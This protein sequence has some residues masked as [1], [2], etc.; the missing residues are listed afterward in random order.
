MDEEIQKEIK[1]IGSGLRTHIHNG[2]ES[3]S[4]DFNEVYNYSTGANVISQTIGTAAANYDAYYIAEK[5]LSIL[6]IDFSAVDALAAHDTNFITWTIT[7]LGQDGTGS[8]VILGTETT[9]VTGG[10]AIAAN[11]KRT[12][13]LSSTIP[14]IQVIQGDRIRIRAAVSGTLANTVT[15]PVYFIQLTQ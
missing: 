15:F 13:T 7:N 3:T 5:T 10:S 1:K 4:I 9:K 2:N 11:T 12:F 14:D 8:A 6:Q